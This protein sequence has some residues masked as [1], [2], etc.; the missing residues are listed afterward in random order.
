VQLVTIGEAGA[1][2]VLQ[3]AVYVDVPLPRFAAPERAPGEDTDEQGRDP[4]VRVLNLINAARSA[5]GLDALRSDPRLDRVARHHA[6]HMA[7]SGRL[8]HETPEGDPQTRVQAVVPH[9]RFA[10]ENIAQARTLVRAHRAIWA[11]PSHRGNLLHP[12]YDS[13][14]VGVVRD[15]SGGWWVCQVFAQ[16]GR[17]TPITRSLDGVTLSDGSP[18]D[19]M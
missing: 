8:E 7:R 10:G 9:S 4:R 18:E 11:S 15:A 13:V 19:S 1:R 17:H 14:G 3:T 6:T 2:P 12:R 5:A 16:L